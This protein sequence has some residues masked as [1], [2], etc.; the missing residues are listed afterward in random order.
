MLHFENI[1]IQVTAFS[2]T[3]SN[4]FNLFANKKC[5][6]PN[7]AQSF[8]RK[9]EYMI[10]CKMNAALYTEKKKKKTPESGQQQNRFITTEMKV[11]CV[12]QNKNAPKMLRIENG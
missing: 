4:K 1:Q 7:R 5:D 8:S 3:H 11:V 2:L 12:R 9:I 10:Y 6:S